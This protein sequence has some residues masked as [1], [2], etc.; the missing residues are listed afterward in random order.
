MARS[1]KNVATKM[2][3][4]KIAD[5]STHSSVQAVGR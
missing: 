2:I 4:D 3:A 5:E 1:A